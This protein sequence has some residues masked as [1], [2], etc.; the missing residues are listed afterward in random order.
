MAL[1]TPEVTEI[2]PEVERARAAAA[3][4]AAARAA[5]PAAPAAPTAAVASAAPEA[6]KSSGW[7][8]RTANALRSGA[9]AAGEA[10]T[11]AP[12]KLA[13]LPGQIVNADLGAAASGALRVGGTAAKAAGGMLTGPTARMAAPIAAIGS[14]VGSYG[15]DTDTYAQRTGIDRGASDWTGKGA[16]AGSRLRFDAVKDAGIRALGTAQDLGNTLTLGLADRVGNALAGNGFNRSAGNQV[17]EVFGRGSEVGDNQPPT[18]PAPS[19]AGAAAQT[20]AADAADMAMRR[21]AGRDAAPPP[22]ATASGPSTPSGQITYDAKTKTYSDGSDAGAI[23]G[24]DGSYRAQGGLIRDQAP[25]VNADGSITPGTLRGSGQ[26]STVDTSEGFRQDKMELQ[27]LRGERAEREASY[28]G[29]QP[30]GGLSGF[31]GGTLSSALRESHNRQSTAMSSDTRDLSPYDAA[32]L[33][34]QQAQTQQQGEL[35]RAQIAATQTG[36]N[37]Q[38]RVAEMNNATHRETNAA[39]TQAAMRGHELDFQGRMAPIEVARQQ[40]LRAATYMQG[41]D[42]AGGAGGTGGAGGRYAAAAQA[43]AANG[44]DAL[45]QHFATLASGEQTRGAAVDAQQASR[46]AGTEKLFKPFFTKDVTGKDGAVSQQFDEVGAAKAAATVR[47][48]Y[49]EKFDKLSDDQKRG[50]ILEVVAQQRNADAEAQ[51]MPGFVDRALDVVGLYD[52]PAPIQ[53]GRRDIRGGKPEKAGLISPPGV[54]RHDTLLRLP[55]GQTVNYGVV[56]DQQIAD[57]NE[58]SRLR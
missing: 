32:Q 20:S 31:G 26:V 40:R 25:T 17:G 1:P 57:I 43:A 11:A 10:A 27:R 18:A 14:A 9:T 22:T 23:P 28:A 7:F 5:T 4:R 54:S 34:Q 50:A 3:R 21:G 12:G 33:K 19:A 24:K 58:R 47:G 55:N 46:A 2:T 45:A 38:L 37:N 41:G 51:V 15:T 56:T 8:R 6:A 42:G 44:D 48:M 13:A 35:G 30:G 16:D 36:N 53:G 29:N 39:T 52:K 49:G